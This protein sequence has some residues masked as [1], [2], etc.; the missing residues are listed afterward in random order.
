MLVIH[1][2]PK[3]WSETATPHFRSLPLKVQPWQT[4][5]SAFRELLQMQA[6]RPTQSSILAGSPGDP[7]AP[8]TD[9]AYI[10][11]ADPLM[12]F[13]QTP[14]PQ[15]VLSSPLIYIVSRRPLARVA[16]SRE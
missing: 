12:T 16:P 9:S 1:Y 6:L 2:I 13:L 4:C 10:V 11:G 14:H 5:I 15:W 3:L 7:C 8:I